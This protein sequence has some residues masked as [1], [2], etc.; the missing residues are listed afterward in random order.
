[1]NERR[2]RIEI[3]EAL[4]AMLQDRARC[5][6]PAD[7][8]LLQDAR[9]IIC[10][11]A[12]WAEERRRRQSCDGELRKTVRRLRIALD[13]L[14]AGVHLVNLP[15]TNRALKDAKADAALLDLLMEEKE[16]PKRKTRPKLRAV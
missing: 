16:K 10:D 4:T 11:A 7:V 6:E 2:T 9:D 5:P 3:A 8:A 13:W 12:V 14:D 15:S 1:M